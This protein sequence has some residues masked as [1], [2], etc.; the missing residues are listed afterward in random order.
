MAALPT[1]SKVFEIWRKKSPSTYLVNL[2]ENNFFNIWMFDYFSDHTTIAST[3]YQNLDTYIH[4]VTKSN[5]LHVSDISDH[6]SVNAHL[7]WFDK[8]IN[9]LLILF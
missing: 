2:T 1:I 5:C 9:Q 4:S 8:Q 3:N 7:I 6:S